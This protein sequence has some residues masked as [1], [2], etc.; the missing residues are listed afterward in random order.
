MDLCDFIDI[1]GDIIFDDEECD[2]RRILFPALRPPA[3]TFEVKTKPLAVKREFEETT[4]GTLHCKKECL[5]IG[6]FGDA[7]PEG[8]K[9]ARKR[10]I[11]RPTKFLPKIEDDIVRFKS[12][13]ER[14][15]TKI[16]RQSYVHEDMPGK[17]NSKTFYLQR[18]AHFLKNCDELGGKCKLDGIML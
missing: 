6:S 12:F 18:I 5:F 17:Q 8:V 7:T 4:N 13:C 2:L 14:D 16:L 9:V 10:V 1:L 3:V 15:P 11:Q